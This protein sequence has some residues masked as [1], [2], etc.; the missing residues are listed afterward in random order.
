M[1][2]VKEEEVDFMLDDIRAR[3]VILEDLQDNLLD[4]MC[5]IVEQELTESDNFFAFYE[6]ML[7]RF[8]QMELKEIQDETDNLLT[9][10]NFYAMKKTLKY[11]GIA[12]T[13]FALLGAIFKI[14]HLPGAAAMIILGGLFFALV[15]L[16]LMIVLKF[17]DEEERTDKWVLSFGF[18]LGIITSSG[19]VFK[20]MHWPAANILMLGGISV[21]VFAYVPIYFMSR[22]RRPEIRF[23]TIVNSVLMMALGS[24]LFAMINLGYSATLKSSFFATHDYLYSHKED[25]AKANS[26]LLQKVA[27]DDSV[28]R[29]HR[30]SS[31]LNEHL[32][33]T[34]N[35]LVAVSEGVSIE[36]ARSIPFKDI[37]R[38]NDNRIVRQEFEHARGPFSQVE[39]RKQ[40][41]DYNTLVKSYFPDQP[42]RLIA[43][44]KLWLRETVLSVLLQEFV[45]I[46]TQLAHTENNYLCYVQA[47]S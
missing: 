37:K 3:G 5:C 44:D 36:K 2:R 35:H 12:A 23:N 31:K 46:Q 38:L 13:F 17:R 34:R 14:F 30:A 9:F 27:D 6:R 28:I 41:E 24:L 20:L 1:Y 8:F 15:F 21:F 40:I 26:L 10:K 18:L 25:L 45:Q 29:F 33:E 42:E 7:P 11:S 22:I 43:V 19:M 39:L 47:K 4:H 32:E 16:P